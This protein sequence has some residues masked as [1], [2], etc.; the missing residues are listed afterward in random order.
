ME[1]NPNRLAFLVLVTGLVLIV[2]IATISIRTPEQGYLNL[3][4]ASADLSTAVFAAAYA[5]LGEGW[6][7]QGLKTLVQL[8]GASGV[9]AI[10]LPALLGSVPVQA[11]VLPPPQSIP[12]VASG[13]PV[14]IYCTHSTESYIPDGGA[15]RTEG[16]PGL[17]LEVARTLGDELVAQGYA[18]TVSE[19]LHDWPDFTA[20]YNHSR[21]TVEDFLQLHPDAAAIIDVHRDAF[22]EGGAVTTKVNGATAAPVLLIVGTD[23]RK[24][25]PHWQDNMVL[26]GKIQAVAEKDYPGLVRGVRAKAGVYNQDLSTR[27]LL[28]EFGT[29][30]NSLEQAQTSA[31]SVA[32]VLAAVIGSDE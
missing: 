7:L 26:A 6:G 18:V 30:G 13:K 8:Y 28:I 15:E 1:L 9:C 23:Q 32:K 12:V 11:A 31:R 4:P 17:I 27:A 14:L 16:R 21:R 22:P 25:H 5:G 3:R 20:S 29:D 10:E 24:P 19:E 2:Y